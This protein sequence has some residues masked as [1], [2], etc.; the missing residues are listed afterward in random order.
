M[1]K[2]LI[3]TAITLG[4][5][6]IFSTSY[7]D[8]D[9]SRER[10]CEKLI[11]I[12]EES[13]I[14]LSADSM[15]D[16]SFNDTQSEAV[17]KI[18]RL[19]VMKGKAENIFAPN[20]PLTRQ[21]AATALY[22]YIGVLIPDSDTTLHP[23]YNFDDNWRIADWA[24]DAVDYL[25]YYEVLLGTEECVISPE[26][27]LT[28]EQAVLLAERVIKNPDK[29]KAFTEISDF[30]WEIKPKYDGLV[31]DTWFSGGLCAVKNDKGYG[32]IDKD[33]KTV[34]KHQFDLAEAFE[35]GRAR[36]T[37]DKKFGYIDKTGKMIIPAEY[38]KYSREF[39]EDM[40]ALHKDGKFGFADKEGNI[41]I[42]FEY[43]Y[44]YDFKD[45]I[46]P[47][48]KDGLYGYIDKSGNVVIDF[49]FKW[50]GSF[51]EGLARVRTGLKDYGYIDHSGE[52]VLDLK[53]DYAFDFN[54]G[55]AVIH[56][57]DHMALIDKEG[58]FIRDFNESTWVYPM[59]DGLIRC[60]PPGDW[61][62]TPYETYYYFVY[63]NGEDAIRNSNMYI[64][65][66]FFEGLA[67]ISSH[68]DTTDRFYNSYIDKKGNFV[69]PRRDWAR[70][71]SEFDTD[72]FCLQKFSEGYA[73]VVNEKGE[74]GFV[75]NPL[76]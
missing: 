57:Y 14:E 36:V 37:V 21:E 6:G 49:K 54:E 43:D 13:N 47:V 68:S 19:G 18:A 63:P 55:T 16:I 41:V 51:C 9:I 52:I 28:E 56:E 69:F 10:F 44:A 67:A 48:K 64:A 4:L 38:D 12:A 66:D 26:T 50:A 3:A 33:G 22:R 40:V 29:F 46:A 23:N 15:E 24:K 45:G 71:E 5:T 74:L 73:A 62:Y 7:A 17:K 75:K 60:S 27:N 31:Q 53:A 39:S 42:P 70:A 30:R 61:Y 2:L 34:I 11:S 35:C 32:Y 72:T 65:D 25:H 58:N 8:A 59:H 76:F 20:D 1:K